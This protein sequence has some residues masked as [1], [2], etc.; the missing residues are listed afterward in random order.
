MIKQLILSIA[1]G[2]AFV[3][4][5]I[6]C[7]KDSGS[8]TQSQQTQNPST[9]LTAVPA[10]ASVGVG[11]FQI[12][13]ISGGKPPYSIASPPNAIATAVL[14]HPDSIIASVTITGV[15]VATA[16]TAVTIR[17]SIA[18]KSVTISIGVH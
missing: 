9:L 15:T 4:G 16:S 11:T 2:V 8:P 6:G 5:S 18:A 7:S 17:D 12:I 3:I 13:S 14:S 10:S 1:V